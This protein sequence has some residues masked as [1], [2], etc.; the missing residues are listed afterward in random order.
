MDPLTLILG[1]GLSILSN[2]L[3]APTAQANADA[4][5]A[6]AEAAKKQADTAIL[7]EQQK[8]KNLQTMMTYGLIGLGVLGAGLIAFQ[9]LKD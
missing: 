8:A 5:K 2:V 4:A 7:L 3:G 6:Q 9:L 1:G